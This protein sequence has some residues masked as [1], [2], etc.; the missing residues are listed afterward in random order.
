MEFYVKFW[1]RP[2]KALRNISFLA[3][4]PIERKGEDKR[5]R[6]GKRRTRGVQESDYRKWVNVMGFMQWLQYDMLT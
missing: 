4:K 1:I 5:K 3:S 2:N 6:R